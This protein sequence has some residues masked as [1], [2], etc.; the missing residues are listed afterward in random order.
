MS[1]Y[2]TEIRGFTEACYDI[3]ADLYDDNFS[4]FFALES[5]SR[6]RLI[7]TIAEDLKNYANEWEK[8]NDKIYKKISWSNGNTTNIMSRSQDWILKFSDTEFKRT[9]YNIRKE[10]K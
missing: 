2:G 1:F 9:I 8:K 3:I 6:I 4:D 10:I 7:N 5:E